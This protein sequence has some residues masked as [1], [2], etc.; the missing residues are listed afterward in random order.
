MIKPDEVQLNTPTRPPSEEFVLPL[1]AEAL[2]R[3]AQKFR[4]MLPTTHIVVRS[5]PRQSAPVE[6]CKVDEEEI[7]GVLERK[8]CRLID[9]AEAFGVDESKVR[10]FIE[11]L[12]ASRRIVAVQLGY[13]IYYK[14]AR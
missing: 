7:L 6:K 5:S 8:P 14:V 3:I 12:V 4:E 10:P 13:D 1:G 2:E 9:I 11:K